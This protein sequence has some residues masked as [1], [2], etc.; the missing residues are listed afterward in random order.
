MAQQQHNDTGADWQSWLERWRDSIAAA[1]GVAQAT[2]W[3]DLAEIVRTTLE[4]S[5]DEDPATV[6]EYLRE[7]CRQWRNDLRDALPSAA[8]LTQT[9]L[10]LSRMPQPD[11]PAAGFPG[12]VFRDA[13]DAMPRLGPLQHQQAQLEALGAAF[14]DY[15]TALAGYLDELVVISDRS[16]DALQEALAGD[17]D[18]DVSDPRALYDLWCQLAEREYERHIATEEYAAA[19]SGVTN[20]W[21]ALQV[22][23]QPLLDDYLESFGIPSRRRLDETQAALD[24]LRRQHKAETR[25]LYERIAALEARL[26]TPGTDTET[27]GD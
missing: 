17:T 16:V 14:E 10:T 5:N 7:S 18:I 11:A 24:Q 19:L 4:Q 23:L 9:I 27:S 26:N 25:A 15:Q 12:G 21:A 8:W 2:V 13:A 6:A 20:S 22:A 1:S 3:P